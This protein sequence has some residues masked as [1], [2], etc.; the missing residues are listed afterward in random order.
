MLRKQNTAHKRNNTHIQRYFWT[1]VLEKT[2][3]KKTGA[4]TNGLYYY[5]IVSEYKSLNALLAI[6]YREYN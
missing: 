3:C 4:T 1:N 2:Q 5:A 6:R